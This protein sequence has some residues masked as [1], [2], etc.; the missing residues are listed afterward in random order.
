MANF[1]HPI[2]VY[3]KLL[4]NNSRGHRGLEPASLLWMLTLQA[5]PARPTGHLR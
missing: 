4:S 5:H 2:F 3:L 1:G